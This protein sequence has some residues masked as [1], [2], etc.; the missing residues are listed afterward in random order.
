MEPIFAGNVLLTKSSKSGQK[1]LLQ[2]RQ[3]LLEA[4]MDAKWNNIVDNTMVRV[5]MVIVGFGAWLAIGYGL[6]S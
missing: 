2:G 4:V 5:G 3:I 6:L 1:E